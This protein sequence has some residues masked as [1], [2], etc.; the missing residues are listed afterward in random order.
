MGVPRVEALI[1]VGALMVRI[2]VL[3]NPLDYHYSKEPDG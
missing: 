3:G 1:N 2:G